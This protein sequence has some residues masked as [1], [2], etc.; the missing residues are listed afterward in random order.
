MEWS[1]MTGPSMIMTYMSKEAFL[2]SRG[3]NHSINHV[4]AVSDLLFKKKKNSLHALYKCFILR[5]KQK[6]L[7]QIKL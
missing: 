5:R 2:P 6:L 3:K 7:L 4:G 1:P